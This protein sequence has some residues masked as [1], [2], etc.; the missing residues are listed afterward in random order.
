SLLLQSGLLLP[1]TPLGNYDMKS[2]LFAIVAAALLFGGF[3][4]FY[5]GG[6]PSVE[7]SPSNVPPID[8]NQNPTSPSTAANYDECLAEGGTL[9]S[10][11][12][13]KCLTKGGHVFIKGVME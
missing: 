1:R 12:S 9:L 7:Q 6:S 10:G 13:G 8:T 4:F 5:H 2:N 11:V 3:F